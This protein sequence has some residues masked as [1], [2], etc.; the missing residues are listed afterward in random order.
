MPYFWFSVI[1]LIWGSSFVLMK[2]AMACLS[3]IGVG[4]GRA[5][6]GALVLAV[7]FLI[8]KQRITIRRR[9]LVPLLL[10]VVL[11]FVWPHSLQP[12]MVARHGG[13]FVGMTVGFTPLL[14][15]LVSIPIL[16]V[17]PT[18]RQ[19]V[20]V[21]GALACLSLLMLD[22]GRQSVALIDIL[23][24]FSVPL[25]Y[26]IANSVIRRS[27]Q[28]L[29]P[30]ELTLVC[31]IAAAAVLFPLSLTV[32]NHREANF[33]QIGSALLAVATL[34]IIGTGIATFLFNRL[35]QEHGPLFAGMTTN[36]VPIGAILWGRADGEPISL[37][38][39]IALTGILVMVTFVQTAPR[40]PVS[41][42][43]SI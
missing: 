1:C 31:L 10:V 14:T 43:H 22:Y 5:I 9:D 27:L 35:V 24:T 17:W 34:G 26:S 11:G 19:V 13:A 42:R 3:P 6:G 21:I 16:G 36:M 38:Q 40:K 7:I 23:L 15:I 8:L 39:V 20:G 25:T 12:E 33:N 41:E 2:R 4:A 32:Q 29:P 28:H 18:T 30:L 37:V